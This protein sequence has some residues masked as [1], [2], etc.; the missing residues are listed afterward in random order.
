MAGTETSAPHG[1][2]QMARAEGDAVAPSRPARPPHGLDSDRLPLASAD[3]APTGLPVQRHLARRYP[4]PRHSSPDEWHISE[5]RNISNSTAS[6][7]RASASHLSDQ[8]AS[9]TS[10]E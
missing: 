10:Y 4:S 1:Q 6:S 9:S 7:R 3:R 5:R 2:V 8:S